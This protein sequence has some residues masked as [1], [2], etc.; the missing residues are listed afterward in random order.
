MPAELL[1]AAMG[2]AVAVVM[3]LTIEILVCTRRNRRGAVPRRS[4]P[5]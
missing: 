2:L 3:A 4:L 1:P 5:D